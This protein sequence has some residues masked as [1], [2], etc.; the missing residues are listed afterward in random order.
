MGPD[1]LERAR[2]LRER[3]DVMTVIDYAVEAWREDIA[4]LK[5]NAEAHRELY[6]VCA[7]LTARIEALE[8]E[9]EK[10]R[11]KPDFLASMGN[12]KRA[13]SRHPRKPV[14]RK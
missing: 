9:L 14:V 7:R 8:A 3:D 11:N 12:Y 13:M 2:D 6:G 1:D 4:I 10:E 5:R